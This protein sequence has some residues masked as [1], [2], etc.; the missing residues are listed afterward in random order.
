MSR[1]AP[2]DLAIV[3]VSVLTA[4]AGE[5]S[6]GD[7]KDAFAHSMDQAAVAA[8]ATLS[9]IGGTP[10]S[11]DVTTTLHEVK[12]IGCKSADGA[13]GYV[14]DVEVDMTLPLM[15]RQKQASS[16]RM[17]ESDDGWRVLQP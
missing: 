7:I 10:G 5:P 15:G 9:A 1:R 4:C 14:C 13:D 6:E 12:K 2:S 3:S 11:V 17:V 16:V 8:N